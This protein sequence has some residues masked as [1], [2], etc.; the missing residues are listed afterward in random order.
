MSDK[1]E[2]AGRDA[3]WTRRGWLAAAGTGLV[4]TALGSG[5]AHAEEQARGASQQPAGDQGGRLP[6]TEFQPKSMLHVTET[7]VARARF[8]V[9]DFH[10]HV[11]LRRGSQRPGVPPAELVKVM[12]AVNLHTMVNLT[13]GSATILSAR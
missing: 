11:S 4:G 2:P 5:G 9:I 13:G 7:Q 3:E 10:T 6:L 1:D 12:D 8:P